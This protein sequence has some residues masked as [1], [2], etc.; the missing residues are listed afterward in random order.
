[1]TVAIDGPAGAGKSTVARKVADALGYT[2]IDSGAMYRAVAWKSLAEGIPPD[3]ENAVVEIAE[4]IEIDFR[5][6]RGDQ[7]VIADGL[8]ITRM[9]R[10][11]E[12]SH[13][14]SVAS[15][16]PGVRHAMVAAQQ[17]MGRG[18]GVVMEG[19]D[20][21]TVVF[22]GAEVKIFLTASSGERAR[23]RY[24]E[25]KGKGTEADLERIRAEMEE[26]DL[27][28]STRAMSPL[29]P[30]PD[31]VPLDTDGLTAG[32]VAERILD[33]CRSRGA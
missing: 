14:A 4:S 13:L 15:A 7:R 6:E 32:Q 9:I 33:L 25:L 19:R 18:G 5:R 29:K 31:A 3:E 23:R 24:E 20:I 26:R 22:P 8:D 30:A 11:Q 16:I 21:G 27:R 17:A 28:D 1:M 12:V 2:Y 10:S